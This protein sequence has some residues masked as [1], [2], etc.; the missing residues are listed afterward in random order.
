MIL[1]SPLEILWIKPIIFIS[2]KKIFL[3][4]L[5][6]NVYLAQLPL[7]QFFSAYCCQI[8]V[9]FVYNKTFEAF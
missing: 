3:L 7:K 8:D 6:I 4:L 5:C 1:D 9:F 2:Q